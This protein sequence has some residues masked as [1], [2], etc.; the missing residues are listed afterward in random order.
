[1]LPGLHQPV[2]LALGTLALGIALHA[3]F[4]AANAMVADVLAPE[5]Y[6]QAFGRLYW[7][8]NVG[9]SVSFALGGTLA[10]HGYERLFWA[11]AV[12]TLAFAGVV[13]LKLPETQRARLDADPAPGKG[14]FREALADRHLVTLL[15]LSVAFFVAMF[16]FMVALP[17][18]MTAKGLSPAEYG[19]AMATNGV[20]IALLQPWA[21]RLT[22]RLDSA[23]V[24]AGAALLVALGYGA[25]VWCETGVDF[26]LATG[27]WS[28]G[29]IGSVPV[30]SALVAQLS[31]KHLRGRYQGLLGLSFGV[32]L[33][34]APALGGVTLDALGPTSVWLGASALAVSVA[35]GHLAAGRGRAT[36][37]LAIA[38]P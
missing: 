1:M 10:V 3:Y 11:D 2:L 38:E 37:L 14:G 8:R 6:A 18:V 30:I 15:L 9:V 16:Q 13:L 35:L 29:E 12:T 5:Q 28:L 36:R 32:S 24:L 19:R 7:A 20:L 17:I 22:Q 21:S 33:T 34:I 4:P 23:Q 26:A 27:V 31:P 25:Y